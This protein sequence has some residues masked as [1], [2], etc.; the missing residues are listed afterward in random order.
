MNQRVCHNCGSPVK[1]DGRFCS[2]CGA[3]AQA[4]AS[5]RGSEL[6]S[7][8]RQ[9]RK[10]IPP[11]MKLIYGAAVLA[12]SAVFL[13]VFA[14]HLPGGAQPV[15]EEQPELA[16]ATMYTDVNLT[17]TAVP[18]RADGSILHVPLTPLLEKKFI[19]FEYTY[20]QTTIPLLAYIAPSGKLVTAVRL[21]E[22]CNSQ[23]FRLEGTELACGNCE[24]RWKLDNLEGIQGSCQKY[25][26]Q[27]LPS[28]VVGNEIQIDEAT[29]RQWK[30]R[31]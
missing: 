1:D 30:I 14:N 25:P 16:M 7:A 13:I 23:T 12:L 26:P 19:Q 8:S 15:I 29:L 4:P 24:T 22:P 31:L 17:A 27:P 10:P 9:A 5:P 11:R 28:K 21:C 20:A 6:P 2:V 3:D 18:A